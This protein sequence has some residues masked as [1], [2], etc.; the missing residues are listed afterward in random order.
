MGRNRRRTRAT[1]VQLRSEWCHITNHYMSRINTKIQNI[2]PNCGASPNDV[3]HLFNCPRKPTTL[4]I[5]SLWTNPR[6]AAIFLDLDTEENDDE[7]WMNRTTVH[8]VWL[9][10]IDFYIH[11]YEI[12]LAF[13][14]KFSIVISGILN[15][16]ACSFRVFLFMGEMTFFYFS[17]KIHFIEWIFL[18]SFSSLYEVCS[19]I[20]VFAM[21]MLL[22]IT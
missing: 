10:Q 15:S 9:S 8:Y 13:Y 2:C 19:I 6:E 4:E 12:V 20:C 21:K 17:W 1:L 11:L 7:I 14:W 5:T 22:T 18:F 3:H 16:W